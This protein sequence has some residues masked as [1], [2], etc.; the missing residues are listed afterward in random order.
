MA[1]ALSDDA[2]ADSWW[3]PSS[4]PAWLN[5][6]FYIQKIQPQLKT[7]MVREI[8]QACKFPSPTPPSSARADAVHIPGTG[9][10]WRNLLAFQEAP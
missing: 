2:V 5:K 7:V 9:R 6:E 1:E 3:S 4:L 8:A 10:H